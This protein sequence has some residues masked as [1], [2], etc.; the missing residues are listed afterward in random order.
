MHRIVLLSL[1]AALLLAACGE[2]K[3]QQLPHEANDYLTVETA[4]IAVKQYCMDTLYQPSH[5]CDG[6]LDWLLTTDTAAFIGCYY[7]EGRQYGRFAYECLAARGQGLDAY[8]LVA[9]G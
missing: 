1:L 8:T 7:D 3:T 2:D 6:Y 4:R 5:V 9:E